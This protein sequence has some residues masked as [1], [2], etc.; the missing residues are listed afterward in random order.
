MGVFAWE[1]ELEA[2]ALLQEQ[3]DCPSSKLHYNS[4]WS[5][6]L[7]QNTAQI[8][9]TVHKLQ[10]N[11]HLSYNKQLDNKHNEDYCTFMND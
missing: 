1:L 9:L 7:E 8:N 10:Q 11:S 4:I 6:T 2:A 5:A 3:P